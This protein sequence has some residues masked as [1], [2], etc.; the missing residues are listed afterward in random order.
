MANSTEILDFCPTVFYARGAA[1]VL[2]TLTVFGSL[3]NK[4][5]VKTPTCPDTK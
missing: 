2:Q 3:A 4:L 1:T 5:L